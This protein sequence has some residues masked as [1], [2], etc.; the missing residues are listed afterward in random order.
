MS[1]NIPEN[2]KIDLD[3]IQATSAT[4][5]SVDY[6]KR[7]A[8]SEQKDKFDDHKRAVS[9]KKHLHNI[10][11]IGMYIIGFIICVLILVRAWHLAT[12]SCLHWLSDSQLHTVDTVLFSS[13]IFSLASRYFSYYN[14]FQ[15][16]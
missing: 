9:Y 3:I 14:L 12:N 10:V 11:V 1:S 13:V 6:S 2:Q 8:V 5:G 4:E 7:L 16:S 15:K